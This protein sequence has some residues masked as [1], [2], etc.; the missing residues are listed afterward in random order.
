MAVNLSPVGGVAAQFFDNNGAPLAG[1]KLYTYA[2]GT[3]TPVTAYT[4]SQGST[5]WSNPIILNSA[6]RVSGSG[7]I[8]ITDGILYK[9]VL[10]TSTGVLIATYDNISGINSNFVAFTNQQ[11]IVAA[12]AGQTVFNLGISYQPGTNSLSVFVDGVNQYGPGAQYAYTETD[13]DTVTFTSGL[14]VGAEVKFTTT[15]QQGAGAI[16]ASQVT[17]DPAGVGAI[18]TNVQEMLRR[19][20]IDVRDYGAVGDG[21]ANDLQA[22]KDARDAAGAAGV[23]LLF[24][25]GRYGINDI[26][27][28]SEGGCTV[29]YFYPGAEIV[30]LSS[31]SVGGATAAQGINTPTEPIYIFNPTVDCQDFAGENAIGA[32]HNIGSTFYN[33]TVRNTEADIAAFGGKAIQWEGG[34]TTNSKVFGLNIEDC[35]VGIDIGVETGVQTTHIGVFNVSMKFVDI[36]IYVNDTTTTTPS[37]SYDQLEIVIDGIQCRNCGLLTY[38]GSTDVGGGIIVQDRGFR[39][40][41][42]N[43]QVINDRGGYGS[44]A[45]GSIGALVRGQGQ[46]LILENVSIDADMTAIFDFNPS[47]FQ[48]A[49][50]GDIASSVYA[51]NVRQ[52]GNLDHVL[53]CLPG[54]NKLGEGVMRLVEIGSTDAS[55]AGIVDANAGAYN[56]TFLELID[57]DNGFATTGLLNLKDIY[58]RGNSITGVNAIAGQGS[59]A[60]FNGEWTPTDGSTDALTFAAASGYWFR[61]GNMATVWAFITYPATAGV[62]AARIGSLPFAPKNIDAVI[63][64]GGISKTTTAAVGSVIPEK[65]SDKA[66]VVSPAGANVA[67]SAMSGQTIAFV[68]TYPIRIDY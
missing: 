6:G 68:L 24:S 5:A 63:G 60:Q 23:P 55:L 26:F 45:Y 36:P 56:N 8:W 20:G 42:R 4:S 28:Y 66:T 35:T 9:F 44:S 27:I 22:L 39:A 33:V 11:E 21:V 61:V 49:F 30:L 19:P 17:Y 29:V 34:V 64:G 50:A 38:A 59:L 25:P 67:N 10:E 31:T 65:S 43:L 12:T 15:Q 54:G 16:N 62:A 48:S 1:G 37:N 57:R 14:H 18:P 52:F 3:T 53:K 2:A 32:T 46:T 13:S 41:V 47:T 7:E 40:T 58:I 51:T